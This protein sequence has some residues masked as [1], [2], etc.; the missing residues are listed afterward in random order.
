MKL[1]TGESDPQRGTVVASDEA[2][3][4]S[5]GS[6]RLRQL[7]RHR[8]RH[9][10]QP[11]AVERADRT[12]RALREA[13]DVERRRHA[14]RRARR[15]RRR[16]RRLLGRERRGGAAA[17]PRHSRR[18]ARA[19]DGRA[20]GRPEDARAARAGAVRPS[21]GAAARRADEPP[22]P[23]LDPLARGISRSL[24]RHADRH[25][26]RS[27]FPEPRLHAHRRHRL[28]DDHHLHRRLRRHGDGQDADPLEDRVATTSSARRRSRSSTTSSRAS[29][30]ARARARRR[31]GARKSSGC[32]RRSWRAR[33]FSARSSSSR[34]SGRPE[35][36]R[37]SSR[38]CQRRSASTQ[39]IAGFSAVVNR[40]EKI[41]LVGRNGVGK[42]TLLK[43]LLADAPDMP[44]IAGRSRRR[45]A[46]LGP[47]GRRSATF[48]RTTP[49]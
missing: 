34:R 31:R 5:P 9:H 7:P 42:T 30:P 48:R 10:G 39:V 20:A 32:R 11:A 23:R 14:P 17:G 36:C 2:R 47:R 19:E 37:S 28:P 18:A 1:L 21:R 40:G 29:A 22:R 16:G 25:L 43:A 41:V 15:H 4:P 27:P 6:V 46:A 26:A 38:G 24:R 33:T 3:R 44:A 13:G 45:Q 49:A 8:H 35:K 12:R